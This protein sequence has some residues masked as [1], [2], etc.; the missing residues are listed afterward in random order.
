MSELIKVYQNV[1]MSQLSIA[2][3]YGGATVNGKPYDY[4]YANDAL[5]LRA[6]KKK[7]KELKHNKPP[8]FNR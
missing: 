5:V 6:Y 2:R 8:K 1:S 7:Y 4:D 3:H